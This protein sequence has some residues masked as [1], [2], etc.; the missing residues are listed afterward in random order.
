MDAGTPRREEP[1]R[2]RPFL[3]DAPAPLAATPPPVAPPPSTSDVSHLRPYLITGGRTDATL[4]IEAQVVTTNTGVLAADTVAYE[5]RD[6]L[7]LCMYP[8]ALAEVA[9]RLGLHLGVARVVAADLVRLGFLA[10]RR[11]EPEPHR[12]LQIIE[13]VIRGLQSID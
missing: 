9:A 6:I 1:S 12:N 10:V 8:V 3:P 13:R 4:E 7:K 2:V 11:P 5:Q